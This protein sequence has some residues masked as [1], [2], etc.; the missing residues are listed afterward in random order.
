MVII[1]GL[2][3]LLTSSGVH[4]DYLPAWIL[5]HFRPHEWDSI[6]PFGQCYR[7]HWCCRLVAT[8]T[9]HFRLFLNIVLLIATIGD[10]RWVRP[11]QLHGELCLQMC[12]TKQWTNMRITLLATPHSQKHTNHKV[13]K[14]VM[15]QMKSFWCFPWSSCISSSQLNIHTGLCYLIKKYFPSTRR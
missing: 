6:N 14:S 9:C 5:I 13:G 12:S 8:N 11:G 3:A 1:I 2:F 10:F 15:P 4:I 7:H